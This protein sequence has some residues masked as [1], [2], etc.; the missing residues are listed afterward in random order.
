MNDD[1]VYVTE[2]YDFASADGLY[3]KL[4]I[5]FVD[6]QPFPFHLSISDHWLNHYYRTRT[7]QEDML[8]AEEAMYLQQPEAYLGAAA[9]GAL[10]QVGTRHDLGFFGLD[11]AIDR[12]GRLIVFECNATMR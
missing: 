2:Y 7:A 6:G 1:A 9:Y 5:I 11:G 4:R 8:R 10:K 3:R 12:D